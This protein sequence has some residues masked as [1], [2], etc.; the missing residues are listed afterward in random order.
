MRKVNSAWFLGVSGTDR[1]NI[2][3]VV[4]NADLVLDRLT[5]ILDHMEN[6]LE[7][8]EVDYDVAS[9]AYQ[10]AHYNGKREMLRQIRELIPKDQE[11]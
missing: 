11:E 2:I 1:Q 3:D 5:V 9:W 10:Q 8:A 6:S 7:R 4:G